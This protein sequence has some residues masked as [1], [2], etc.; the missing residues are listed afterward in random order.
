M[1]PLPVRR[2]NGIGPK[3]GAR[4]ATLGTKTIAQLASQVAARLCLKRVDLAWRIRLLGARAG[5][6]QRAL[7]LGAGAD[8]RSKAC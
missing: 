2:I 6:L 1:W 4:L 3:A 7:R 8:Q 5:A